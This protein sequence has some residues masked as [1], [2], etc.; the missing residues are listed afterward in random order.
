[1]NK[2]QVRAFIFNLLS[3]IILFVGFRY[4]VEKYTNLSGF[5]IPLTAFVIGTI[6]APKFQAVK[7][8]DGE[9]LFMKWMFLKG[10]K[11]IK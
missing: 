10:I 7:T 3:F 4:L 6:L 1:M 8:N 2:L 11:E 9:K 5:W